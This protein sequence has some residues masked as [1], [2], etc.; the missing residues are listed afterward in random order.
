MIERAQGYWVIGV[1]SA[2]IGGT[3][4][5]ALCLIQ[6]GIVYLDTLQWRSGEMQKLRDVLII[7]ACVVLV[8]RFG[9]Y[10]MYWTFQRESARA[11]LRIQERQLRQ[12]EE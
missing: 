3:V 9:I 7:F 1:M 5:T 6:C 4:R 10:S 8:W 12:K 2:S 11:G